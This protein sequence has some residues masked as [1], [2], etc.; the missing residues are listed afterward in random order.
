[1]H[2]VV[3]GTGIAGASA[4]YHAARAGARVTMVDR[5][6]AGRATSAGAG[7]VCPWSSRVTDPDWYRLSAAGAR[8]YPKLVEA[9]SADGG[10]D[11]SYRR[12]G[13]LCLADDP[14]G[15]AAVRDRVLARRADAPEAGEVSVLDPDDARRLFPPLRPDTAAVHVAGAA[16]VDG[17]R[18][19]AALRRSAERYGATFRSGTARLAV[20]AGRV[21]GVDVDGTAVGADAVVAAA[22]A[23]TPELLAGT[24][25]TVDVAPQRGQIVHLGLSGVDTSAWPVVLPQTSHYLLAFDDSRVVVGATRETG[26]GFDH[27]VTAGGLAEVLREALSVAPGLADAT[28]LSTRIGFRPMGPSVTPLLGPVRGLAGLVMLTGLGAGGLTMGPYAGRLAASAALG[29][30]PEIDLAPYDPLR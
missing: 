30:T 10:A 22:G 24:G 6:A 14:D 7:I 18:V 9:L 20:A 8:Y 23:W 1:M 12:V 15:L 21:T 16:R 13:A 25:V 5:D 26:S 27:R 2:V 29:E 3:V 28:H 4:A 17:R 19:G 11:L